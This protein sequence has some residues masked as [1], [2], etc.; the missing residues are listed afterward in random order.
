[1]IVGLGDRRRRAA[2][3]SS[4]AQEQRAAEPIIPLKLFRSRR[5]QRRLLARLRDR[6]GD[7]RRDHLHPAVPAARLRR[8]PDELGPAD[9][10]A[11]GRPADREHPLRPRDQPDRPLQGRSRSPAPRSPPSA[12]SCSRGWRSTRRRGWRRSTC[13]S[14]GVGIGLVMQVHRARR[15]ERRAAARHRRRHLDG[16]VLPLAWAARSASRCS[17]RSSPRAWPTSSARCRATAAAR[18]AR[19]RQHQPGRRST[20]CRPRS[21]TTSCS[22]SSTRSSRSSSSARRSR[23]SPFV[24]AWLLKEVPLRGTNRTAADLTAEEAAA[25]P[26]SRRSSSRARAL[27]P[28]LR[29]ASRTRSS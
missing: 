5:L 11:D 3:R 24:L 21:A 16:D 20:R 2:R 9:A 28:A 4:S 6:P 23:W 18:F 19:R 8:Q 29:A 10:A 14:L 7:V 15:P 25:G 17:A 26:G 12:C 22:R 1:M 27:A 13:S